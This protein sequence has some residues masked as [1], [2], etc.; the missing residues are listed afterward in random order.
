M[1]PLRLSFHGGADEVT[2]SRHLLEAGSCRILLDC[3]LF[4]GHRYEAIEKNRLFPFDVSTLSAV[5]LSHA[6]ID[7]SGG[8]PLLVKNGF[9][10][11]IHCTP[12]TE[13]LLRIML[14]DS[15]HI[16]VEDAKFFN[17][18]NANTGKQ[19][20]PLY[21]E[22]DVDRA[23]KLLVPHDYEEY[24]QVGE[25]VKA[26]FLSAG[27]VLG[28]AMVQVEVD[29]PK[30]KRRVLFTGDLGR[31]KS[32][33]MNSP[34]IPS[35]VKEAIDVLGKVKRRIVINELIMLIADKIAAAPPS[36]LLDSIGK[37]SRPYKGY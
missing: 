29:T 5:L 1:K 3:G 2:G 13:E 35:N 18:I 36:D 26:R 7:H 28:S 22:E 24:F 25:G 20:E 32:I 9:R 14:M 21:T 12:A 16:Q 37:H 6:H 23:L 34:E 15:A 10:Q 4:Q 30:G 33:L 11:H 8:L 27:H 31:R 19:I 17:K